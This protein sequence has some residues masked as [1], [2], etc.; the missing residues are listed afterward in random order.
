MGKV[1][2]NVMKTRL[3]HQKLIHWRWYE[4]YSHP[5]DL[6]TSHTYLPECY[7][8]VVKGFSTEDTQ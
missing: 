5:L 1:V 6:N 8:E 7:D 2:C 4:M 3:L